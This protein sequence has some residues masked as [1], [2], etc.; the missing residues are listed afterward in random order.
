MAHADFKLDIGCGLK[1]IVCT[2][3]LLWPTLIGLFDVGVRPCD[4]HST[5]QVL[6]FQ[7]PHLATRVV[8]LGSPDTNL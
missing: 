8:G 3:E 1:I 7:L 4:S 2:R 6:G 5:T